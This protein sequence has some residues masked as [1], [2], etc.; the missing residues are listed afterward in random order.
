MEGVKQVPDGPFVFRDSWTWTVP[1]WVPPS[2]VALVRHS[3]KHIFIL[4]LIER[5]NVKDKQEESF[6]DPLMDSSLIGAI[7]THP[8][9]P[10][11]VER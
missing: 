8:E 11:T 5:P 6:A 9:R 2:V 4:T 1:N 10:N 7:S 3:G